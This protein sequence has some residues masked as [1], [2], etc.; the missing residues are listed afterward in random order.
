MRPFSSTDREPQSSP[1][2]P[3]R[4]GALGHRPV[5]ES[6]SDG[7]LVRRSL[8]GDDWAREALFR[9]HVAALTVMATNLLR[10][11]ADA[12]DVAQDTFA[13]AYETLPRL[14]DPEAFRAWLFRIAVNRARKL[15]R[16]RRLARML[17][18]DR[19]VEDDGLARRPAPSASPEAILDL[20]RVDTLMQKLPVE[21]RLA[22]TL[23]HVEGESLESVAALLE[24][25]LST[26]KR[27]LRGAEISIDA[28]VQGRRT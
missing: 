20:A 17:G 5:P 7:E 13:E 25:S 26:A 12:D 1:A 3:A 2:R 14:R 27:R 28:H 21:E 8:G 6:L 23:H 11:R 22:W 4:S 16:R 9:R 10:V 19:G 15:M 24:C 18:L